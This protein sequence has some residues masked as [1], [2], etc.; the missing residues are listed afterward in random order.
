MYANIPKTEL[1]HSVIEKLLRIQPV[2]VV[3][4]D[5]DRV[6]AAIGWEFKDPTRQIWLEWLCYSLV[7]GLWERDTWRTIN[8]RISGDNNRCFC[9]LEE[10]SHVRSGN[11]LLSFF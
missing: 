10:L 4:A 7:I 9:S 11:Y 8:H 1:N 5:C 2:F 6:F 3:L